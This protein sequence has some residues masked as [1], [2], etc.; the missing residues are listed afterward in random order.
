MTI[1]NRLGYV[2]REEKKQAGAGEPSANRYGLTLIGG[3][4]VLPEYIYNEM[5][6]YPEGYKY[7]LP[8]GGEGDPFRVSDYC[9]YYAAASC[10]VTSLYNEYVEVY[11]PISAN[12]SG[13]SINFFKRRNVN[14]ER[15]ITF[16]ELYPPIE[17]DLGITL[18]FAPCMYFVEVGN[19]S[20]TK[21]FMSEVTGKWLFDNKG[22]EFYVMQFMSTAI[23]PQDGTTPAWTL[24]W[25]FALPFKIFT[26]KIK[27]REDAGETG[28]NT[29]VQGD[30]VVSMDTNYPV[31]NGIVG[32]RERSVYAPFTLS[33]R[34]GTGRIE[35]FIIALYTDQKCSPNNMVQGSKIEFADMIGVTGS[36]YFKPTLDNSAS[37]KGTP[38]WVGIY[39]NGNLQ[40]QRKVIPPR[41]EIGDI[42]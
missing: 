26:M 9:G 15:E 33:I 23:R 22:K 40:F 34:G 2:P 21:A 4:G 38:V 29:G 16:G 28:G 6:T 17:N 31:F 37:A 7:V 42:K 5:K 24:S 14:E 30:I 32:D 18:S 19:S 27:E 35:D 36:R 12:L 1:P 10:P 41:E 8:A 13:F 39:F 20:N 3:A 25:Q 11:A